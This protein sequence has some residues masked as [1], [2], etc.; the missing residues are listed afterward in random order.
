MG[1]LS[2]AFCRAIVMIRT[3]FSSSSTSKIAWVIMPLGWFTPGDGGYSPIASPRQFNPELASLARLR[4][5][6]QVPTQP[7]NRFSRNGQPDAGS[8]VFFGGVDPLE[9][10]KNPRT[11]F[12][13]DADA[14]VLDICPH[15]RAA[16]FGPN[17]HP[18]LDSGRDKFD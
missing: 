3:S 2:P 8:F 10:A 17:P 12:R 7:L 9:H 11:V 6:I 15:M 16:W 4:F 14:V 1:Q 5:K 13:L 18:R